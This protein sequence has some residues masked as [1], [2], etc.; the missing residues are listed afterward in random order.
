MDFPLKTGEPARQRTECAIL[1]VFDDGELRG[2]TKAI[3]R[4]ARGAIKQLVRAGDAAGRLGATTLIHRT[5]GAAAPLAARRLRQACGLRREAPH[6]RA[7]RRRV[8]ALRGT[9]TREALSYLAY[10]SRIDRR[11]AGGAPKRRGGT[12]ADSIAST[13]SRAAATRLRSS[14]GS[15]SACRADADERAARRGIKVGTAIANG[16][17]LARDLG[18]R[19]PNVCTPTHLAETA[20]ALAK[21]F[22]NLEVKVL[23]EPD[24][25]R[26]G[27]GALLAVTQGADGAREASS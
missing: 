2:A 27:M 24:M 10:G 23:G 13:S 11:R 4:A 6:H 21:R 18:N 9:G 26:L 5:Q 16:A 7:R 15:A 25:R 20:R 8:A 19:P 12:R 14:R 22:K 17:D 3:D 1:P